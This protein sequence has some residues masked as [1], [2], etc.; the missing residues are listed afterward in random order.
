MIILAVSWGI[1]I[2]AITLY[3][4]LPEGD[5]RELEKPPERLTQFVTNTPLHFFGGEIYASTADGTL[6]ATTCDGDVCGWE[7]KEVL[8]PP[9]DKSSYWSGFCVDDSKPKGIILKPSTPGNVIDSYETRYCG[10]DYVNN[11]F[12]I[13]LD[14][15]S[16][17]VWNKF[18]SAYAMY[19]YEKRYTVG[20]ILGLVLGGLIGLMVIAKKPYLINRLNFLDGFLVFVIRL[21]SKIKQY[22]KQQTAWFTLKH[23]ILLASLGITLWLGFLTYDYL[24]SKSH[25]EIVHRIF[26]KEARVEYGN[27]GEVVRITCFYCRTNVLFPRRTLRYLSPEIGQLTTLEVLDL[28]SNSLVELP[29]EIG[30]LTNLKRLD[31]DDNQLTELPSEIGHLTKLTG[32]RLQNNKLTTLPP[33]FGQLTNLQWRLYLDGNQ[34]KTLPP[35]F[36][37]LTGITELFLG[38]NQLTELPTEFGQLTNL[39]ELNLHSNELNALPPTIGQLVNLKSLVLVHNN[40]KILP[41]ELWQLTQL[42][43]LFLG[44]N[45]LTILPNEVGQMQG[46]ETLDLSYNQL[47]SLPPGIGTLYNLKALDL[48]HN[49]LTT[50]PP[51]IGQLINLEVLLLDGNPITTLP[52]EI[53]QLQNLQEFDLQSKN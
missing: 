38:G 32:I 28:K 15:G 3:N 26:K 51:E 37:Q 30:Q 21:I 40:L 10:P 46:L 11:I 20:T 47:V 7:K 33:E 19:L 36:G 9:A 5:W 29:P 16:V 39:V 12:F 17:W 35:E 25:E 43:G 27:S 45:Q 53:E 44:N 13:L 22:L 4:L 8:P 18:D 31:L 14:D 41:I 24:R 50:L 48:R 1:T 23:F 6:Y 49:N 2:L 34:L 42:K 52:P